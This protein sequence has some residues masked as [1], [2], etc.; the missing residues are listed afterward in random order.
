MVYTPCTTRVCL[1]DVTIVCVIVDGP[2][3]MRRAVVPKRFSSQ[4]Q[5]TL[6]SRRVSRVIFNEKLRRAIS[7]D[8][9]TKRRISKYV[10]LENVSSNP[11]LDD[12]YSIKHN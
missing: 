4:T 6:L 9:G 8:N 1:T 5:I 11:V 3:R 2:V 12:I 10:H 7:R